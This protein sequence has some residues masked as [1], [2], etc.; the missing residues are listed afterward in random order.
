[1]RVAFGKLVSSLV[2]LSHTSL[3]D[4]STLAL[5]LAVQPG[6]VD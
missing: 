6:A 2:G 1:V 5:A 4:N 3:L